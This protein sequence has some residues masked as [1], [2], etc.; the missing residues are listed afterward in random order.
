MESGRDQCRKENCRGCPNCANDD[1]PEISYHVGRSN[2]SLSDYSAEE[3]RAELTRRRSERRKT[4]A[5]AKTSMKIKMLERE[6]ERLKK[7][8]L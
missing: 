1:I 4:H 7:E 8:L 3:I 2:K 5:N 6:L